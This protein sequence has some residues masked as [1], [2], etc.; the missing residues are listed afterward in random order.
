MISVR[1]VCARAPCRAT[2]NIKRIS[3]EIFKGTKP[4][5]I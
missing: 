3:V 4:T 2:E 1:D 5:E